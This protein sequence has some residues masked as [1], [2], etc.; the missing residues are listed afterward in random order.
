M[1]SKM[2]PLEVE[3][4][5]GIE[6]LCSLVILDNPDVDDVRRP[7]TKED[8]YLHYDLIVEMKNGREIKVD[9]KGLKSLGHGRVK[10]GEYH[11]IETKNV[12]GAKG[13]LYGQADVISFQVDEYDFIHV[14]RKDLVK[15][16][17]NLIASMEDKVVH[18]TS[19]TDFAERYVGKRIF[20]RDNPAL[21]PNMRRYDNTILVKT[22]LLKTI[23]SNPFKI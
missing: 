5:Q 14:K 6:T 11:W 1:A 21:P 12:S 17:E 8:M 15:L 19:P 16:T 4:S 22:E 7:T 9:V 10:T 3:I 20:T 18:R 23:A 2:K 13:W